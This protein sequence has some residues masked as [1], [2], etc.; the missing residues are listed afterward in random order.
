MYIGKDMKSETL[1]D[2]VN[3]ITLNTSG[4]RKNYDSE[5]PEDIG[6]TYVYWKRHEIET[7]DDFVN[8]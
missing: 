7:L 6:T 8:V 2:F 1:E 3:V 5:M 4:F